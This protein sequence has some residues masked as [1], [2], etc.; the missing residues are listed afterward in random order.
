MC[1]TIIH[2]NKL[3]F[4]YMWQKIHDR[5]LEGMLQYFEEHRIYFSLFQHLNGYENM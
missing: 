5:I 4:N 3:N 1:L 2:Y